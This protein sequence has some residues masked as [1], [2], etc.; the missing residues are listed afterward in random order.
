MTYPL[1]FHEDAVPWHDES[2]SFWSWSTGLSDHGSWTSRSCIVG[3]P[4]SRICKATREAIAQVISWDV[5]T[6]MSGLFPE[7]DHEGVLFDPGSYRAKLA[8]QTVMSGRRAVFCFWKG[9][10]E[11]HWLSHN[12]R[13]YYRCN[14]MCDW[15]LALANDRDMS[16]ADFRPKALWRVTCDYKDP[17]S[18][19][20]RS[21][22]RHVPGYMKRRRLYDRCLGQDSFRTF[23]LCVVSFMYCKHS[24]ILRLA[25]PYSV[26]HLAH[27]GFLRDV[28]ASVLYDTLQ[29][30][31]LSALFFLFCVRVSCC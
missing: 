30:G 25:S 10:M 13:R 11:A 28:I 8:G 2:A 18:E 20:G 31:T 22:W 6:L 3:L 27:L 12:L 14:K 23:V 17:S 19:D 7:V 29:N 5:Q 16:Y 21:Y 9:D 24:K 4:T 26:M 1:L 15:C